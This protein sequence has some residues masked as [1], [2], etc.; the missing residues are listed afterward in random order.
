[1]DAQDI[2]DK[3]KD[4]EE[5]IE[6]KNLRGSVSAYI[7]WCGDEFDVRLSASEGYDSNGYWSRETNLSGTCAEAE[8]LLAKATTWAYNIPNEEDR[9]IEF[10]IQQLNKLVEK[11]PKGSTQAAVEAWD[12]VRKMILARAESLAQSGLPSPAS[13]SAADGPADEEIPY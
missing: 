10:M 5:I 8:L 9:A 2:H 7:H 1:M 3:V 12:E 4:I 6:S 11:L 13:I